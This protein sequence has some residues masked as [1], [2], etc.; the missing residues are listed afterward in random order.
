[1][2]VRRSEHPIRE[3]SGGTAC[4]GDNSVSIGKDAGKGCENNTVSIGGESGIEAKNHAV[5]V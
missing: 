5:S 3:N 1:M 2:E 4:V